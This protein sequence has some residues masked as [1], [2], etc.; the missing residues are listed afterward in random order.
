[1]DYQG[2]IRIASGFCSINCFDHCRNFHGVC[3]C[4]GNYFAGIQIHDTVKVYEATV[5]P[6]IGYI[7]APDGV[8]PFWIEL[9]VKDIVQFAAK[10]E[11]TCCSRPGFTH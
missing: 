8:G 6:D 3:E 10:V 7:S 4:P 2:L 5:G 1:M 9:F 11:I